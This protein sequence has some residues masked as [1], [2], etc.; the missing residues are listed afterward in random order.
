MLGSQVAICPSNTVPVEQSCVRWRGDEQQHA[1]SS[2]SSFLEPTAAGGSISLTTPVTKPHAME[3]RPLPDSANCG[4][5]SWGTASTDGWAEVCSFACLVEEEEEEEEKN[6]QSLFWC[7]SA[8]CLR[9]QR[10]TDFLKLLWWISLTFM[11]VWFKEAI[12]VLW[13]N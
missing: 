11:W 13:H 3:R 4:D 2:S 6:R 7:S 12:K 5:P 1:L 9:F 10:D 8:S